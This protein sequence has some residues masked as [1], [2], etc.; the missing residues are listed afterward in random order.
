MNCNCNPSQLRNGQADKILRWLLLNSAWYCFAIRKRSNCF[1]HFHN[2]PSRGCW[3]FHRKLVLCGYSFIILG[4][5][6]GCC[7]D[8][9]CPV[10]GL[11]WC[12]LYY[13][14]TWTVFEY[15]AIGLFWTIY[16]PQVPL[17]MS[18]FLTSAIFSS[19]QNL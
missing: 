15:W 4:E 11:L 6:S 1:P 16:F 18:A 3:F 5:F 8:T 2:T 10:V 14:S 19:Y 9:S 17:H 13:L 12:S 7:E